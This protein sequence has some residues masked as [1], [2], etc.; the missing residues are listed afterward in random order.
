MVWTYY[1][2][3]ICSGLSPFVNGGYE[4]VNW[5]VLRPAAQQRLKVSDGLNTLMLG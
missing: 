2:T 5:L 4:I 3:I 1:K